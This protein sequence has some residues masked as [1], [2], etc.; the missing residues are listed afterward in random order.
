VPSLEN[1]LSQLAG[2]NSITLL[3]KYLA[4]KG[5]SVVKTETIILDEDAYNGDVHGLKVYLSDG[6]VY[7]HKKVSSY[8]ERGNFGCDSYEFRLEGEEVKVQE[9]NGDEPQGQPFDF[10]AVHGT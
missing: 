6:R 3:T 7:M 2:V 1:L 4:D 10:N 5:I 9:I 8:T